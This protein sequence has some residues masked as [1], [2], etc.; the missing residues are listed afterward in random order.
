MT[1]I[2]YAAK[3]DVGKVRKKNQDS[4][5]AVTG[6]GLG[7][8]ADG[9]FVVAD[10]M[11][12]HAGGEI[13]S[14]I[15]VETVPAIVGDE[16]AR[17]NGQMSAGS[18]SEALREA[19]SAANEAVWK[20]ARANPELRGM[21]T[22]CVAVLAKEGTA[23]VGNV[24]DSRAYLLRGGRLRQITADHS[25]V[26]EH[27]RAG[28]MTADEARESRFKNVITRGIGLASRVEPDVE[29]LELE[30]GD[31]LLLCSDGLSGMVR[32]GEIGRI[33]SESREAREAC[34]RL[35][36]AANRGGGE[37]NISAVVIRYG[38]F[39]PAIPLGDEAADD[40]ELEPVPYPG[41]P[42]RQ[43]RVSP[44][45]L[46]LIALVGIL[47]GLLIK[48]GQESYEMTSE[49]PFIRHRKPKPPTPVIAPPAPDLASLA[50]AAP[51]VVSRKPVRDAPLVCDSAGNLYAATRQTGKIVRIGADGRLSADFPARLPTDSEAAATHWASD[52]QGN[53]YVS[54]RA[55]HVIRKYTPAGT[56]VAEIGRDSL[57]AP[58]AIA[59]DGKG[60]VYVVDENLVK[61]FPV[62]TADKE[63]GRQGDKETR[64]GVERDRGSTGANPQ[65]AIRN[66]Q[67]PEAPHG[68]R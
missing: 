12:G 11:G 41:S 52:S 27:V 46:V 16:L 67:S 29:L 21:G 1:S 64:K 44:L 26:Q 57:V 9:L 17:L 55:D 23:A 34:D 28:E 14:R 13:A 49:A 6:D 3:T 7:G 4:L 33:L 18:L 25:L 61:L 39:V 30:E 31:T 24:G 60:N 19:M 47:G 43:I 51:I 37:D 68:S 48:V 35:V 8:R 10:G 63:T 2:S 32:D 56:R 42:S 66:P 62:M 22:T 38:T 50:Y 15:T 54:F 5:T 45:V 58:G 53:L 65:S 20:Q 36:E 40:R 59:V